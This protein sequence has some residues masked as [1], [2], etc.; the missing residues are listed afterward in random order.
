[1]CSQKLI[2]VG[3]AGQVGRA[4]CQ[5]VPDAVALTRRE[6]DLTGDV[7]SAC[8]LYSTPGATLL[9]LSAFTAVDAAEDAARAEEVWAVNGRAPGEL[10]LACAETGMRMI[11]VST[12]YVFSGDRPEGQ[13]NG[14]ADPVGPVN[15]YG[16]SK[17]AGERAALAAGAT[18]V[19]TSWVYTGPENTGGDFVK[20]MVDL[21]SRGV[22]LRVV[23]DQWG[24]PTRALDLARALVDLAEAGVGDNQLLHIAGS[25]E[26]ITWFTFA[27]AVFEEAGFDPAR[28]SPVPTREYPTAAQRPLN[29]ALDTSAYEKLCESVK[30]TPMPAWRESLREALR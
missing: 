3:A 12:D 30:L 24:R 22:D 11:H 16:R 23:D 25:G 28:V 27:R 9:N 18:V 15:E 8:R 19:R 2:V 29:A 1:M 26:P 6:L 4:V 13:L 17:L 21:A 20:T 10:A 7:R 5:L 14:E